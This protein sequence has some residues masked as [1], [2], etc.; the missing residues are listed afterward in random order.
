MKRNTTFVDRVRAE[1]LMDCASGNH[2]PSVLGFILLLLLYVAAYVFTA[3]SSR[4]QDVLMLF[5]HPTPTASFTGVFSALGNF[6]I[7]FLVVFYGKPG[8][9]TALGLLL[10]QLTLLALQIFKE[11]NVAA[12]PGMFSALFTILVIFLFYN[13][14]LRVQKYQDRLREQAIT[15]QLTGLP[16]RFACSE[17]INRLV[18]RRERFAVVSIDLNHFKA[19]NN[20]MGRSTGNKVLSEIAR[21]WEKTVNTGASGTRDFIACQGGVEFALVIQGYQTDEDIIKSINC[22]NAALEQKLTLD[23]CDYYITAR[24]GYAVYPD[25][26]D[27]GDALLSYAFTAMYEAKR[28]SA[29]ICRFSPDMLKTEQSLE[30]ERKIRQALD[31][32]TLCFYLQPQFDI[33]HRLRGFE[34]LA[35]LKDED[36]SFISPAQFIPVAEKAGLIDS[37]DRR[38]FRD[39]ALF[40]GEVIKRTGADLTLSVN[41][42]A[43]HL[44]RNDF[45]DEV[46]NI[47]DTCGFPVKDLEIEI[48]ES[49]MIDSAEAA[50]NCI[51]EIKQM[52]VKIALDDFG[53]GYSSLSYLNTFPADILKVDKSFIDKM[54][55]SDSSKQYVAAII[56]IGHIMNFNVISEGVEEPEQLDTLRSIGCDYIQ[57]YIWGRP[58]PPE[59]AE[60]LVL[61]SVAA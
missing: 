10:V 34:A 38:V 29:H 31:N 22:Y 8:F 26:A 60:A 59:E 1:R 15:D 24:Y 48:T 23:D 7:I 3:R 17:L 27:N 49:V 19:I 25:D 32:N 18:E 16:N 55:T 14:Y 36:G 57:G 28:T 54:N 47:V 33:Q 20:T 43:R 37:I 11:H 39:S 51:N 4:A 46:R 41:V 5:G 35:R 21:R 9:F 40:L 58:L 52:G 44:M 45:L 13:N 61:R 12:V 56:S 42:S 53:T 6:C 30:I 2:R 50:L